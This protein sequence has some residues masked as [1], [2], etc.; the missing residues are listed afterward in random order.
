MWD[1]T[2]RHTV[3]QR[4][5]I[6]KLHEISLNLPPVSMIRCSATFASEFGP[7]ARSESEV[8]VIVHVSHS[9]IWKV[10]GHRKIVGISLYISLH[11][12][13]HIYWGEGVGECGPTKGKTPSNKGWGLHITYG[14]FSTPLVVTSQDVRLKIERTQKC[15]L[16]PCREN[17]GNFRAF[18]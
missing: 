7:R 12:I 9:C 13:Y 10:I 16:H 6:Y 18:K 11:T 8:E 17:L 4:H 14:G 15:V 3:N 5:A 2:I 1:T